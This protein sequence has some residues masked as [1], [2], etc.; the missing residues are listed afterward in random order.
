VRIGL[1]IYKSLE[2]VSG[3][4]LYDQML[5]NQLRR[6]GETV[7]IINLP[8][9]SYSDLLTQNFNRSFR[10][11]LRA[12]E[13]DILLEDELN[14]PSLFAVNRWLKRH[15]KTP[16][17]SIVHHLRISE[18][19]P[20]LSRPFYRAVER[21][22][23]RS[24]DAFLYNSQTTR[25]SVEKLIGSTNG[26]VA[27]PSGSRFKGLGEPTVRARAAQ[28]RQ[29]QIVFVGNIIPRKGLHV[30]LDAMSRLP[31]K[32]AHL[33]VI[34]SLSVDPAYTRRIRRRI[35]RFEIGEDV[36]LT[37]AISDAD[38]RS[39][40]TRSDLLCVP[41]QH[42]GFGIVY[43]EG[44]AFGL[45]AIAT[46]GGAASEIITDGITGFIIPPAD[47]EALAIRLHSLVIDRTHL[48]RMSLAAHQTYTRWPTWSDSMQKAHRFLRSL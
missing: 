15:V 31:R 14:H 6:A 47:P 36:T 29:L 3:G 16:I 40:L 7:E 44:F 28:D 38:L 25:E 22:Y 43:L 2:T 30:L 10:K 23:L 48:F 32:A 5:V 12:R 11:R 18:R 42:E 39:R 35:S 21:S 37:D 41:S 8:W 24:V 33:T 34:G 46:T 13:Y 19:H 20:L 27:Y 1:I 9:R 17:V 45:P 4:F 26:I